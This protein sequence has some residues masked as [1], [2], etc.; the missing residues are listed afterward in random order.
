MC[1]YVYIYIQIRMYVYIYIYMYMCVQKSMHIGIWVYGFL[2]AETFAYSMQL[3]PEQGPNTATKLS[4][5]AAGR[6]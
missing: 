4:A 6:L 2:N 3:A 5:K 1:M